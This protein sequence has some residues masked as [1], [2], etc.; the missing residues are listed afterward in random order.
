MFGCC[1]MTIFKYP[2][3]SLIMNFMNFVMDI[4]LNV[5][6]QL[7]IVRVRIFKIVLGAWKKS[8]IRLRA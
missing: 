6:V 2:K 8:R 7:V 1:E 5:R 3:G 4:Q